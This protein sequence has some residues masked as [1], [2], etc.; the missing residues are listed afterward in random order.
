MRKCLALGAAT[1]AAA[2]LLVPLFGCSS[3]D[4]GSDDRILPPP[5]PDFATIV[6]RLDDSANHTFTT[7]DGLAWCGGF[8]WDAAT[9]I[10]TDDASWSGP[11]PALHDD[12]PAADGGHEADGE[13]AGDG[14]WT[15]AVEVV[16]PGADWTFAYM[17][18]KHSVDGSYGQALD[19]NWGG[20]AT[21]TAGETGTV[22]IAGPDFIP[23]QSGCVQM[24]FV[25]DDTANQSYTEADGLA[26]KGSF[27][28]DAAR[29]VLTQD[30]AWSGPFVPLYDDGPWGAGGHEGDGAIGGDHKW[31]AT[32]WIDNSTTRE[33]EYG[34]IRGSTAGSDGAWIWSGANGT[35]A[36]T[37][38]ATGEYYPTGLTIP[39]WGTIDLLIL[40][41]LSSDGGNLPDPWAGTDWTGSAGIRGGFTGWQSVAL[42]AFPE[43]GVD[44]Y[45]FLLSEHI[46]PHDGLLHRGDDLVWVMELGGQEYRVDGAASNRMV[47][48]RFLIDEQ[49]WGGYDVLVQPDGDRYLTITVP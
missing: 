1:L 43:I 42:R 19:P 14:I 3:D 35:F 13:T 41:D 22:T 7:G 36:V 23:M 38:G 45:G 37:A 24:T 26:W 44:Y 20:Q 31:S 11:F 2:C 46:G 47:M 15:V 4:D 9:G 49:W 27:S 12:G 48:P 32:V 39:A 6:Y 29:R 5:A 40:I 18:T 8:S 10:I 30:G 21:V 34:A 25:I 28:Y 33:F 17:P 16:S